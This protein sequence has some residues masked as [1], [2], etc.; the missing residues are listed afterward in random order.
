MREIISHKC[1]DLNE[2]INICVMDGPGPGGANHS[3]EIS[4]HGGLGAIQFSPIEFQ[5]G[6]VKDTGPNG[7]SDEALLAIVAD[8]LE[9]FQAG[10]FECVENGFA[11]EHVKMAIERLQ[12]RTRD[13]IK[14]GVEGHS[15]R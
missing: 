13:R 11:L 12:G 6:A 15:K 7:I 3:Y 9:C 2:S 14:R 10:P 4:V 1:S 5:K 8:R